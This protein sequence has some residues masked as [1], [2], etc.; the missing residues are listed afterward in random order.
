M[1][2]TLIVILGATGVGKTNSSIALAQKYNCPIISADSRQ[3]YKELPIGTAAPTE[4]ELTVVK[5]YFIGSHSITDF[6]NAGMYEKDTIELLQEIF[7]KKDVALLVGG[8]MMYIDAVCNGLD[9]IPSVKKE[10]RNQWKEEYNEKGLE[11]IQ[12]KL[13]EL[14]FEHYNI[15]D[16]KN[17]KR[18]L[19]AL[20]ICTQTGKPYSSFRTGKVR[21][22][23]FEIIKIGLNRERSELYDRINK[24]VDKMMELGLLEEALPLYPYKSLNT[25]NTVGYKEIFDY[26][27]KKYTLEEAIDKI[28]RNS[29]RYAKRQL[30][31][32]RRDKNIYWFHPDEKEKIIKFIE[33]QL[34]K[35][36]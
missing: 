7:K 10:I 29:R 12:K 33:Q 6:Y 21:K 3:F 35:I 5:H 36:K 24:R 2:K 13:K 16:L 25:L 23:D 28:K 15:V 19:H 9:D 1:K 34:V 11:Y 14:D 31:W 22:R 18:V 32:F 26:I 30:T 20:E 27:D 8:S 4:K 17:Y